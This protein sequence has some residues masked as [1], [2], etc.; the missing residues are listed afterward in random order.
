MG[1]PRIRGK[2]MNEVKATAPMNVPTLPKYSDSLYI[3]YGFVIHFCTE[4]HLREAEWNPVVVL[5]E[6]S[7]LI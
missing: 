4:D 5:Q 6:P 3:I 2:N 7:D 1:S